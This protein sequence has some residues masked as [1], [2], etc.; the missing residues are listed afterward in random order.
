MVKNMTSGRPL[1]LLLAFAFP[2]FIGNIFQLL[3]GLT[4][5]SLVGHVLGAD[6]LAA[7]GASGSL[8]FLVIGL[9]SGLGSGLSIIMAQ[10]F[11]ADDHDG[12]RH[13]VAM[14]VYIVAITTLICSIAFCLGTTWLLKCM[15]VP[16][17][18][19]ILAR[20]YMII[21]FGFSF[22]FSLYSLQSYILRAL[23][24]SKTSLYFL[25]LSC[26]INLILDLWFMI[27]FGWGVRG[28]A[29][30][31]VI[32]QGL[33]G[34]LCF[35][36]I[37]WK[38]PILHMHRQDWRWDFP[39]ICEHLRI[40]LP[41]ALQFSII[42]IGGVVVQYKL[43]EF[44]TAAIASYTAS[45]RLDQIV[46]LPLISIGIAAGTFVAQNYG[47]GK[48]ERVRQG[49]D[50]ALRLEIYSA[51]A[52][53]FIYSGCCNF[54]VRLFLKDPSEEIITYIRLYLLT[55]SGMFWAVSALQVYRFALQGTGHAIAP[56][57]S[58]IIEM[59]IRILAVQ[60]L[61]L[62]FGYWGICMANPLAWVG[63]GLQL[64][65]NYYIVMHKLR[66][67]AIEANIPSKPEEVKS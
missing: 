56:M 67:K 14:S 44:G 52:M 29:T 9:Y 6:A 61:P 19:L 17:D 39:F 37:C 50:T 63:G 1:P 53:G 59:V 47:A 4:D 12:V 32:S 26:L 24:D 34:I 48:I 45:L 13:S 11:G 65:I 30:A 8:Q 38:F 28:A 18:I 33:A 15:H 21:T 42:G 55:A 31:T 43:N 64:G 57:C 54:L 3:Y 58:G 46:F 49:I 36:L 16:K 51:L 7:V 5:A 66:K 2:L 60:I 35:I 27:G 23:G 22:T 25:I 20:Q 41:M 10:R 62:Y 40:A